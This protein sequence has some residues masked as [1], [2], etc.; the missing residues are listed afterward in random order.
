[1]AHAHCILDT[2]VYKYTLRIHNNYCLS[3]S[4][5]FA[6]TILNVA[7]YVHCLSCHNVAVRWIIGSWGFENVVILS[8]SFDLPTKK[9]FMD[10]SMLK[11]ETI[12]LC[13]KFRKHPV[14]FCNITGEAT[15]KVNVDVLW[16]DRAV[17]WCGILSKCPKDFPWWWLHRM[18]TFR[19]WLRP[20]CCVSPRRLAGKTVI[21][22]ALKHGRIFLHYASQ[23]KLRCFSLL[24]WKLWSF[25]D[26]NQAVLSG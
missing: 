9:S 7:L 1:M 13:G 21:S 18:W 10:I 19:V 26:F 4:N 25:S 15:S 11:D 24:G 22:V 23:A 2:F 5:L 8:L 16:Q 3:S 6:R 17:H 20:A 12:M 14:K